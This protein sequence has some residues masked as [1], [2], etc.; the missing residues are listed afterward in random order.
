[1]LGSHSR[2]WIKTEFKSEPEP[3]EPINVEHR[4]ETI[5]TVLGSYIH[6]HGTTQSVPEM[7]M[8]DPVEHDVPALEEQVHEINR[9]TLPV[10]DE[11]WQLVEEYEKVHL[12]FI[13]WQK[14]TAPRQWVFAL[15]S[16]H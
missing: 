11:P 15:I 14:P 2:P 13:Y 16:K 10:A 6:D 12:V 4:V 5:R 1:M 7:R 8:V 3:I 9:K